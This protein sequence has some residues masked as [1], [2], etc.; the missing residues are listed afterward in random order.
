[1]R[2]FIYPI[3]VEQ[4]EDG[5]WSAVV[6]SLPGCATWGYTQQEA[7]KALQEAIDAYIFTLREAGRPIPQPPPNGEII[8]IPALAVVV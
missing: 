7:V 6:P 2:T 1:M 3:E 8:E 4:E 5:R